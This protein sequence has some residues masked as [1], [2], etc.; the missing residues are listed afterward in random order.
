MSKAGARFTYTAQRESYLTVVGALL[1]L[2]VV[3]TGLWVLLAGALIHN[4]GVRLALHVVMA[5]ATLLSLALLLAPAFTAHHLSATHLTLR[6]GLFTAQ[7]PRSA[8]ASAEPARVSVDAFQSLAPRYDVKQ[9]RVVIA[10][11]EGGEVLVRL[12]EPYPIQMGRRERRIESIL[13]NVDR[14]G[15]LLAALAA[16]AAPATAA[17]GDVATTK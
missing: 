14:R 9:R 15:D 4:D 5:V 13:L 2:L 3:E 6:Y 10:F 11:S 17:P 7:L 1:F 8:I 12:R 16:D